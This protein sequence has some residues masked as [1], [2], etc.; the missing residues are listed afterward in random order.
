MRFEVKRTGSFGDSKTNYTI[1]LSK[2]DREHLGIQSRALVNVKKG[3]RKE[4]AIVRKQ[5][6]DLSGYPEV[7]STNLLLTE[8]LNLSVNDTVHITADVTQE[9]ADEYS[10]QEEFEN[11]Q[12][13]GRILQDKQKV[14]VKDVMERLGLFV[15][16]QNPEQTDGG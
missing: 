11:R 10:S 5:F 3:R 9:E 7:C 14:K 13:T 8:K 12:V 4:I 6:I 1:G 16:E 2:S 15:N